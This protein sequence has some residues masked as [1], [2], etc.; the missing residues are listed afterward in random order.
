MSLSCFPILVLI[1]CAAALPAAIF[2]VDQLRGN[3]PGI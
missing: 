1:L 3:D 2:E